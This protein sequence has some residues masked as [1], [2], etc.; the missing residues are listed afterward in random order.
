MRCSGEE[1]AEE[2]GSTEGEDGTSSTKEDDGTLKENSSNEWSIRQ[3][4]STTAV[5]LCH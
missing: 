3:A 5:K 4:Y 1:S 2:E